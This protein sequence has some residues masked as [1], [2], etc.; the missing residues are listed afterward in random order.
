MAR[1]QAADYEHKRGAITL[2]AAKL[3]ALKGFAGASLS[4]LAT[5]CNTSKSLIYH[6][7]G[8]KEDILYD[9]M[10]THIDQLLAVIERVGKSPSQPEIKFREM[11]REL[12]DHYVDAADSQKVLLYELESLPKNQRKEIVDKQR[13]IIDFAQNLLARTATYQTTDRDKLRVQVMLFFG[14]LNW[15]HTWFKS[16]GTVDRHAVADEA[17]EL[18][19]KI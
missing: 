15:T 9:L 12:L 7:Y 14:M 11:A 18:V 8:S 10:R 13:Y 16:D 2:Q 4:E 3:F 17:S 1:F 6:Y 5:A 19:L